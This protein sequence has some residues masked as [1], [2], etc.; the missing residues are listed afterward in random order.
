MLHISTVL[1]DVA[2]LLMDKGGHEDLVG[3]LFSLSNHTH[4]ME[5]PL[6]KVTDDNIVDHLRDKNRSLAKSLGHY[7]AE[8]CRRSL[9]QREQNEAIYR[10]A[11]TVVGLEEA[12]KKLLASMGYSPNATQHCSPLLDN[13]KLARRIIEQA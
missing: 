11:R 6:L 12:N 5:L 7:Q 10:L 9:E 8:N 2:V 1:F 4:A 3:D 13:I